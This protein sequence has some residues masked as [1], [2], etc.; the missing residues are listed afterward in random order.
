M[1]A[2]AASDFGDEIPPDP[3]T[4]TTPSLC[5]DFHPE[6]EGQRQRKQ[7]GD[8]VQRTLLW[9]SAEMAHEGITAGE[10]ARLVANLVFT[11]AQANLLV[12]GPNYTFTRN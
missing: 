7:I 9:L 6:N 12:H 1:M 3:P 8:L 11:G 2:V 10:E 4:P 5:A